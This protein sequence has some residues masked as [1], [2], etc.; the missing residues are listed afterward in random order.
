MWQI[1]F[2]LGQK[3]LAQILAA[4]D[5]VSHSLR[6]SKRAARLSL[7]CWPLASH[8]RTQPC[9]PHSLP[10][11]FTW[12]SCLVWVVSLCSTLGNLISRCIAD[13]RSNNTFFRDFAF[14]REKNH[15][16]F[17]SMCGFKFWWQC[18]VFLIHSYYDYDIKFCL[19]PWAWAPKKGGVW[20]SMCCIFRQ[21]IRSRQDPLSMV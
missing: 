12:I 11:F 7:L 16:I 18:F 9:L 5:T 4:G 15:S 2:N 8:P 6:P 21:Y 1:F 3:M 13:Y 17:A 14:N 20:L 19:G 10:Y